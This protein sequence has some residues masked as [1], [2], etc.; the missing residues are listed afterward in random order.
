MVVTGFNNEGSMIKYKAKNIKI[1][2][3]DKILTI[4]QCIILNLLQK[5]CY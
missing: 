4:E 1:Q 2:K 3:W 5:I